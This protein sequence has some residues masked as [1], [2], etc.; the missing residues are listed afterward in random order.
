MLYSLIR[1]ESATTGA[2]MIHAGLM[3]SVTGG[4]AV[5]SLERKVSFC[6]LHVVISLDSY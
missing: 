1:R 4:A 2:T 5:V 3:I 6:D